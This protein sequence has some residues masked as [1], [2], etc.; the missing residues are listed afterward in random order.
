MTTAERDHRDDELLAIRCQMGE[1]AGF[2]DLIAR[3]HG[4]LWTYIRRLVGEDDA[5][6]EVV[7]DVWVRV[8][9]GIARLRDGSKLRAWLFGIARR[10]LMDRLRE[11]YAK[12]TDPE[13]DMDEIAADTWTDEADA[14]LQAL[15][16]SLARLPIVERE[17]LT[18]FYLEELS[19][20]EVAEA[21]RVPVGNNQVAPVP[22]A[23]DAAAGHEGTRLTHM[24]TH[25][26]PPTLAADLRR[27]TVLELSLPARMGYIALLLAA[28]TM[29]AIVSALLL[30][31]PGLPLRTSIALAVMAAIGLSWM[32]FAVWVLSHKRIL[33]GRQRIVASRLAVAFGSVFVVGALLIGYATARPSALAAAGLGALMLSVALSMLIRARRAFTQL[34][35]RREV[36]ERQLGRS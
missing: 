13:I 5:A 26:P 31:E 3:W 15:D 1:P 23:T 29:T 2:D 19:L 18:L 32:G 7:Q 16:Y 22:R 35:K 28:S 20:S 6:R 4:P 8:I 27:L 9:R 25:T 21:L 10:T 14:D 34:S 11:Q 24:T 12:P 33:L 17:V 36:L 30:T